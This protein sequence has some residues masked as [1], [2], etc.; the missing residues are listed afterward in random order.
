MLLSQGQVDRADAGHI[1]I[2]KDKIPNDNHKDEPESRGSA[3]R[4]NHAP[5]VE[6]PSFEGQRLHQR[7]ALADNGEPV[8]GA[9]IKHLCN[10]Q[11]EGA[12]GGPDKSVLRRF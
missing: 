6:L 3:L 2:H 1:H 4:I 7:H 8:V 11:D 5:H 12:S 9:A 10:H